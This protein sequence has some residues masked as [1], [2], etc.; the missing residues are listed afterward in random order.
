MV[1]A[2]RIISIING[3]RPLGNTEMVGQKME[4]VLMTIQETRKA[5]LYAHSVDA[6]VNTFAFN[7][8]FKSK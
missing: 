5:Q 7:A 1:G 6:K 2:V 8:I 3:A 4:K